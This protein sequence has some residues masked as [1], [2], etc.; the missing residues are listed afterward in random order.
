MGCDFLGVEAS[1]SWVTLRI[2]DFYHIREETGGWGRI[3]YNFM[4]IDW[5]DLMRQVGRRVLAPA[6]LQEGLVLPPHANDGVPAPLS[7]LVHAEGR[8]PIAASAAAKD[9]LNEWVGDSVESQSWH[10]DLTFYGPGG[11]GL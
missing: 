7:F 5:A 3:D 11:I 10:K 1:N 9:A 4:M 8:D 2:T 6:P